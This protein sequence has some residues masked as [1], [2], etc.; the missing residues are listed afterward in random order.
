MI[1]HAL[2]GGLLVLTMLA[3]PSRRPDSPVTIL[4]S[5]RLALCTATAGLML[6][7]LHLTVV[8]VVMAGNLAR[9]RDMAYM[10]IA[11]DPEFIVWDFNRQPVVDIP[12]FDDEAFAGTADAPH[13]IILFSDFQCRHCRRAHEMIAEVLEAF[14]GETRMAYRY[15]PQDPEC[16]PRYRAGG[17]LSACRAARAAEA[18]RQLA[19]ADAF[20]RMQALLYERQDQIPNRAYTRQSD[21]ERRRFEEWAS[22]LGIDADAFR[23]AI[24]APATAERINACIAQAEAHGISAM[25]VVYVDGKRLIGWSKRE[26]WDAILRGQTSPTTQPES[27][28]TEPES[29]RIP[30]P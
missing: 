3:W 13:T 19:G 18:V 25:P 30:P 29:A 5:V 28:A 23:A 6:G 2:N 9:Q 4:P 22:E 1:A 27:A 7:A 17:H 26:V 16:N 24:D 21:S 12:L 20:L 11:N 15:Y 10:K 8:F 14:P